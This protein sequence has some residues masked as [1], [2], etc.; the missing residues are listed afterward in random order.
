MLVEKH[1][2]IGVCEN[3]SLRNLFEET[4]GVSNRRIENMT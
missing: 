2:G 1:E 3:R 4:E